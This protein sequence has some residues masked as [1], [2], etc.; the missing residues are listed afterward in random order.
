MLNVGSMLPDIHECVLWF[1]VGIRCG[2]V[3]SLSIELIATT[4][5]ILYVALST[6][7]DS[8]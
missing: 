6:A 1:S 3:L 4:T 8:S 2:T 7:G 5:K